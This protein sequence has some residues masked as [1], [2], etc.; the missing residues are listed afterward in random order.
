VILDSVLGIGETLTTLAGVNLGTG[1]WIYKW[2]INI[3]NVSYFS[4]QEI[5]IGP[6]LCF[7]RRRVPSRTKKREEKDREREREGESERGTALRRPHR[8]APSHPMRPT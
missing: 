6:R 7:W 1:A 8:L 3:G 2:E 5:K 4:P